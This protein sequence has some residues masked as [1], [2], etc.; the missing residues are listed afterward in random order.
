MIVSWL[1]PSQREDVH[2]PSCPRLIDDLESLLATAS[3]EELAEILEERSS[4]L[5]SGYTLAT[6]Y[7]TIVRY[8]QDGEVEAAQNIRLYFHL[9]GYARCYGLLCLHERL[10]LLASEEDQDMA[11]LFP[12]GASDLVALLDLMRE[13]ARLDEH[14]L[15]HAMLLQELADQQMEVFDETHDQLWLERADAHYSQALAITLPED[16]PTRQAYL[17]MH[18]GV[19][20]LYRLGEDRADHVERAIADLET[21]LKIEP[22]EEEPEVRARIQ[23]VLGEAYSQRGYDRREQNLRHAIM[24]YTES[25]KYFTLATAVQER[26]SILQS[27]A[28]LHIE[29]REEELARAAYR[30][31]RAT[32][33]ELER[34]A[35]EQLETRA[36]PQSGRHI[37]TRDSTVVAATLEAWLSINDRAA[38]YAFLVEH[39][40]NLVSDEALA[41][42]RSRLAVSTSTGPTGYADYL[43]LL[44]QLLENAQAFSPEVAW[45]RYLAAL[46]P[47]WEAGQLLSLAET[48]QD[49]ARRIADQQDL[50]TSPEMLATFYLIARGNSQETETHQVR[51]ILD[52]LQLLRSGQIS[53]P[54]Q[55]TLEAEADCKPLPADRAHSE[56]NAED[57]VIRPEHLARMNP[58]D[59]FQQALQ[60]EMAL[61][62]PDLA[63]LLIEAG[64][65]LLS[66]TMQPAELARFADSILP[67]LHPEQ[68]PYLWAQAHWMRVAFILEG[69]DYHQE[70][71]A[72]C[73]TALSVVQQETMP[74]AWAGLVLAR[75]VIQMS[76][77]SND[78]SHSLSPDQRQLYARQA[79]QDLAACEC[80]YV[81]R[82]DRQ[83]EWGM[84]CIYRAIALAEEAKSA[85]W[86]PERF[87]QVQADF[88]GGLPLVTRHGT[89][90]QR[91]LA[92]L[93]RAT[94]LS[95][96][97]QPDRQAAIKRAIEDC[98]TV[99][100]LTS[101]RSSP[102]QAEYWAEALVVRAMAWA[103][104][105]DLAPGE[106][107]ARAISDLTQALSVYTRTNYPQNWA[108]TLI[109][110]GGIYI[111][112]AQEDISENQEQ[113]LRD[114]NDVLSL[115]EHQISQEIAGKALLNRS[116]CYM[117]RTQGVRT[118]NQRQALNDCQA[119][120]ALFRESGCCLDEAAALNS[121]GVIYLQRLEGILSENLRQAVADFDAAL[122]ILSASDTPLF[123]AQTLINRAIARRKQAGTLGYYNY[124]GVGIHTLIQRIFNQHSESALKMLGEHQQLL[125]LALA[126]FSAALT[127][128]E[129][130]VTPALWAKALQERGITYIFQTQEYLTGEREEIIR[131]GIFDVE[132]ALAVIS[133]SAT[134]Y[135]W[136]TARMNRAVLYAELVTKENLEDANHA[137]A[138]IEQALEIFT[139]RVTPARHRQAQCL[140]AEIFFKLGQWS[141][142]HQALRAAREAE[143]DLVASASGSQEQT[144][145]IA[146]LSPLDV[147]VRDAWALL[148]MQPVDGAAIAVVLEEGRALAARIAFDLDTIRLQTYPPGEARDRMKTFLAARQNLR[149]LQFQ[150][151]QR[152]A[153]SDAQEQINVAYNAFDR[154][155]KAIRQ[156]DNPDFMTPL[157]TLQGIVDALQTPDEALV[158][159]VAG[160]VITSIGGMALLVTRDAEGQPRSV[161]PMPLPEFHEW[162]LF[163]LLEIEKGK[164][165]LINTEEALVSLGEMGLELVVARLVE[166]GIHTLRLIPYGWLGLFPW[167]AVLI[168]CADGQRRHLSE[169]FG[170]VT[171]V[172]AARTLQIAQQRLASRGLQRRTL[173]IAGNPEPHP[174]HEDLP[175]A[176]AEAT[177]VQR[178][179]RAHGHAQAHIHSLLPTQLTRQ[180][181]IDALPQASYAHLAVHAAYCAEDPRR[182]RLLLADIAPGDVQARSLFLGEILDGRVDLGGMRLLILSACETSVIDMQRVPNEAL[183]LAAGFLQAGAAAVIAALWPVDDLATFLLMTRFAQHYLD[184]QGLW[185]P[186]RALAAAQHWLRSEVTN[187]V[188]ARYDP[189]VI[190]RDSSR[191]RGLSLTASEARQHVRRQARAR[192]LEGQG[193]AL[194]YADPF[195]WASFVVVGR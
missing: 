28:D 65:A 88:A 127:V 7:A 130:S 181:L 139:P 87:A 141:Q 189:A 68:T 125:D 151:V 67:S 184:V 73:T 149:K 116:H 185:S 136:A 4:V 70:A 101:A 104:R 41:A 69:S 157:P 47:A 94:I 111:Q 169:L 114:V 154:A 60:A 56:Q 81:G 92:H 193:D 195:Y 77:V 126:D 186:A 107:L 18:R 192:L 145:I 72:D 105:I 3:V 147:S 168:P 38:C 93:C 2:H 99:I 48:F 188:L 182:S 78:T 171:V 109:N 20:R 142:V 132:Q 89:L 158:Y 194:P 10:A 175:Y 165:P 12:L 133:R 131:R 16:H 91:V 46:I 26:L 110:R 45:Q 33:A 161:R 160:S 123:W 22:V 8:E 66:N 29:L 135:D 50:F 53:F 36:M 83:L 85:G 97:H 162:K 146:E 180:C 167:P 57:F 170:E 153:T 144:D 178:I 150:T 23:R 63:L 102:T 58:S 80:S 124:R 24:A 35:R 79:L 43:T 19:V 30:D 37:K 155:R 39:Q 137:L 71:L 148:Q 95:T 9:L 75:G 74:E 42:L 86:T 120:L 6:L 44:I 172:P 32:A 108:R 17:Y 156:H 119:A 138:D 190:Q 34:Q 82:D 143:R 152:Q 179:A 187:R 128:L 183:G 140:R 13:T 121:R 134:P 96:Y 177:A 103:E 84:L 5:L 40:E 52:H 106:N 90:Q 176:L 14:P 98:D 62:P 31:M 55:A 166:E 76:I 64:G 159:L 122:A 118:Q 11:A 100:T 61:L 1:C 49:L 191:L 163:D 174:P 27:L 129:R 115:P 51:Q 25:L 21:A 15:V 54:A 117:I 59:P 173:L 113:A 164:T 112:W